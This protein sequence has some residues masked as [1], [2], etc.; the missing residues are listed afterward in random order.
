M[1]TIGSTF[2]LRNVSKCRF[3]IANVFYHKKSL[4]QHLQFKAFQGRKYHIP[5]S[6]WKGVLC[7]FCGIVFQTHVSTAQE[8]KY[9][10]TV[11]VKK[12][13]VSSAHPEATKVGVEILKKGGNAFDAAIAVQLALAVVYPR[14]GNIGGGGFMVAH[15]TDGKNIALDYREK[16][17]AKAS[18]D[19]YLDEKG[20]VKDGL[21]T[22][23]H[24]A[25]GVP[26]TVAG[27]FK[28]HKYAKLSFKELIQPAINLAEK[29]F[30]LTAND[31][32]LYNATQKIFLKENRYTPAI[33]EKEWKEGDVF[34]Q[35]DL[36]ETLKR[37]RDKGQAGF[38]E[39]VNAELIVEEMKAGK[40]LITLEDLKN[41]EAVER[42]ALIFKYKNYDIV[43]MP[44]PSSG[45]IC[46][47][48]IMGMIEPYPLRKYGFQSPKAVHLMAEAE[49]RAYSD[50]AAHI[51][52]PDF[53][54]VPQNNLLNKEYLRQRM[55]NFNAEKATP[56]DS[57]K[58]G[59]FDTGENTTHLSVYD[60]WGNAVSV[61]TTLNTNFGS[62]VMVKGAGFFLNNEMDDFSSKPGVPN[63][64]GLVGN[65]ANAIAPNKRMLSSMT[66]TIVLKKNNVY[67]IVGTPGGSTII[68]SVFQTIVNVLEFKMTLNKAINA[69]RFHHQW[70]PDQI[71]MEAATPLPEATQMKLKEMGHKLNTREPIGLVDG[72]L[73]TKKGKI[74]AVG[75]RRSDDTAGGF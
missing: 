4:S 49:R 13:A 10:K 48:Q 11:T 2:W 16:A 12:A 51:G 59:I 38:Y 70:L 29:G 67:L 7:L 71:L 17:P 1:N 64:Y 75:D 22:A 57:T 69:P 52:D 5:N 61:T 62:K 37:I 44:P 6:V 30:K 20:N 8:I 58:A 47:A 50:R 25:V 34:I 45:G 15:S 28:A 74:Q 3:L 36:A 31:A 65:E 24:L 41:Y 14:A 60:K 68:T 9:G 63:F 73:I 27:L 66:P 23:G 53:W 21:S 72:I 18:R 43:S 39:G 55:P 40:G 35:K 46:L 56:S 32:K 26:G 42:D 54:N 19:M 33:A